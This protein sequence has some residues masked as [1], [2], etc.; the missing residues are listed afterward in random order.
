VELCG[1]GPDCAWPLL[2]IGY[3]YSKQAK[4]SD[5]LP[6][7][8]RA[9]QVRPEWARTH[10]HLAKAMAE[11]SD[12]AGAR[13]EL[14]QAISLD[15]SQS[16]YHYQLAQV[17]RRLGDPRNADIQLARFRSMQRRESQS[18]QSADFAQP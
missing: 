7:F 11:L 16:E 2:Q 15:D 6:Y 3:R 17:Y 14:Q 18:A 5:A 9:V 8:R 10:F 4:F 12:L 13:T 1:D